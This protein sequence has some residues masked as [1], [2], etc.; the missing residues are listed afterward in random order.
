METYG[1]KFDQAYQ[2]VQQKRFCVNPRETFKRQLFVSFNPL[3]LK[4]PYLYPT[5]PQSMSN[6]KYSR[7][8]KG[9]MYQSDNDLSIF[10]SDL[11]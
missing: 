8:W 5:N 11:M 3:I 10:S 1:L 7:Q 6:G 4:R 2:H 9:V